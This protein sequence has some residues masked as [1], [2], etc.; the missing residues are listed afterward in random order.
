MKYRNP[1]LIALAAASVLFVQ[2]PA[3]AQTTFTGT[4]QITT[5]SLDQRA[6]IEA[7]ENDVKSVMDWSI[8]RISGTNG[9]ER[10]SYTA[11]VRGSIVKMLM[12]EGE[13]TMDYANQTFTMYD[14]RQDVYATWTGNELRQRISAMTGGQRGGPPGGAVAAA[15]ER[16]RG[17]PDP[18]A[19]GPYSLNKNDACGEWFGGHMGSV[20]PTDNPMAQGWLLHTC[21]S[22]SNR[23]AWESMKAIEALSAQFD[24]DEQDA[25]DQMDAAFL[26][27]GMPT[28]TKRLRKGGGLSPS[29]DF[30]AT[31]LVV[32][33]GPVSA[34][35]MAAKGREITL[36]E[37]MQLMMT[38][39]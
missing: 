12:P 16:M 1:S 27:R 32:S 25:E 34:A 22:T 18:E 28:I 20:D 9:V 2:Q 3:T 24:M 37:L 19:E 36:D 29:I 14:P 21:V 6:L 39:E 7:I 38:R 5:Y 33:E 26:K 30:E 13:M 4:I 31:H 23:E 17:G 35:E 10:E 8:E 11:K 15:L